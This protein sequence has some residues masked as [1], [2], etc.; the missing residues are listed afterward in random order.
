MPDNTLWNPQ[1]LLALHDDVSGLKSAVHRQQADMSDLKHHMA[2]QTTLLTRILWVLA[3]GAMSMIVGLSL[4][5]LQ[6]K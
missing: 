5:V 2:Y 6:G 1:D 4:L 3:G